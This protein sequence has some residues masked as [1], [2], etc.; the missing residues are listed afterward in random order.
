MPIPQ[1]KNG[2]FV[3]NRF[4]LAEV[5]SFGWLSNPGYSQRLVGPG[6]QIE[7]P[8]EY[9]QDDGFN[10]YMVN[11]PFDQQ[12]WTRGD[13]PKAE[14]LPEGFMEIFGALK[15]HPTGNS[16]ADRI[17]AVYWNQIKRQFIKAGWPLND[18]KPTGYT[19]KA[20][21]KKQ[22]EEIEAVFVEHNLGRPHYYILDNGTGPKWWARLPEPRS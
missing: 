3:G 4:S 22:L 1:L 18:V 10:Y 9:L 11:S 17:A 6:R 16:Q 2:R 13:L 12:P 19:G 8:E 7:V 14:P 20:A 15:P 5:E 21:T